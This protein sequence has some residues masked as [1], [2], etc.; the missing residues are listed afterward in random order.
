M[1]YETAAASIATVVAETR[2]S[3]DVV[4]TAF[5]TIFARVQGLSLGESLEDGVDLNKYSSA[6]AKIGV[7][8]LTASGELRDMDDILNDLGEKWQYL[9]NETQVALAQVVGGTRQYSQMI[10]LMD[11]W[12]KVTEN[13]NVAKEAT[14]ELAAQ[15]TTWS[16][17]YEG[18]LQ[19][20]EQAK[21]E[22]YETFISDKLLI[23]WND[24]M[25]VLTK[26]FSTFV[27]KIGGMG[28]FVLSL[29]GI[30]SKTLFPLLMNGISK[31]S[32]MVSVATG[33]AS[34]S[35]AAMQGQMAD[36]LQ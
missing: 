12:D 11:N 2:Q 20:L 35:V 15:Q 21:K 10:A 3:A 22:L 19:R 36:S 30:F 23:G 26:S 33:N 16:K 13:I 4:G 31:L 18:S 1:E 32:S 17:S 8:V 6:L 14:G 9:G 24:A 27:E 25:S 7:D 29:A 5:K 28:P 34:R